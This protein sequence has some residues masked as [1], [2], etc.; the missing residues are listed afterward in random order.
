M[1]LKQSKNADGGNK[2]QKRIARC[3]A[4]LKRLDLFLVVYDLV[5]RSRL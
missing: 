1:H 4:V 2:L 3:M 5:L